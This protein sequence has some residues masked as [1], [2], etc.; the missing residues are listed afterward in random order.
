MRIVQ[1][2]D[3]HLDENNEASFDVDVWA[4]YTRSLDYI[5]EIK[6]DYVVHTG[7]L[8]LDTGSIDIYKRVKSSLDNLSIPYNVLSGNHDDTQMLTSVF[9]E[10]NTVSSYYYRRE[11]DD[12]YHT[13]Y[14]DSSRAKFSKDQWDFFDASLNSATKPIIIFMHHPPIYAGVKFLDNRHAFIEQEEFIDLINKHQKHVT[15]FCGHYHHPAEVSTPLIQVYVCPSTYFH[16]QADQDNFE[17]LDTR[18]GLR[19]IEL[20][21]DR[22]LTRNV[23]L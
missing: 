9:C 23:W 16:L 11:L 13:I 21:S 17:L 7:D 1:I 4:H 14:L 22:I 15:V 8:V 5:K 10:N 18:P 3:T 12:T 6:A 2:S 20:K 19:Y